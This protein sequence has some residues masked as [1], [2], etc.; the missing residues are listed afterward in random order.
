MPKKRASRSSPRPSSSGTPGSTV[1]AF[2]LGVGAAVGAGYL[3]LHSTLRQAATPIPAPSQ[4]TPVNRARPPLPASP[5]PP[6]APFGTSEDVFEAGAHVY[7]ARCAGCH[8]S[9]H[10]KAASTPSANQFWGKARHSV[11]TQSPG[12]LYTEIA[13]GV[14]AK[15]MPAYAHILTDTQIWQV[16]LLLKNADGDLPDPV[17]SILNASGQP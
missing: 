17:V 6:S 1:L 4:P 14:P 8:G 16:A 9:P 11:A 5:A 13:A 2:V 12:E 10:Q 3:Y 7:S 15:G